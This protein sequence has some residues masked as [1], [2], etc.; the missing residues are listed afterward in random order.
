MEQIPDTGGGVT[1]FLA[2][3][4]WM[5]YRYFPSSGQ[6]D[7]LILFIVLALTV[8]FLI[9]PYLWS[10]VKADIVLLK[11]KK[12]ED[13]TQIYWVFTWDI[14]CLGFLLFFFTSVGGHTFLTGRQFFDLADLNQCVRWT[15]FTSLGLVIGTVLVYSVSAAL[16]NILE[17]EKGVTTPQAFPGRDLLSLYLGGGIFV[18]SSGNPHH[19]QGIIM[20]QVSISK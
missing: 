7:W 9:L 4:L 6:Y 3:Y 10:T 2:H 20:A 15:Y 17:L 8:N 19:F 14:C 12:S 11:E 1:G 16:L 5:V 13:P 18:D